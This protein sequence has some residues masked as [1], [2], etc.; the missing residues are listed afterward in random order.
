MGKNNKIP[1]PAPVDNL[2][3]TAIVKITS[4]NLLEIIKKRRSIRRF[5][6]QQVEKEKIAALLEAAMYAPSAVNK[7]PW[8]FIVIDDHAVMKRIME[9][10]PHSKMFETANIGVLVCGD[11]QLHH[12]PG[13][14][15][16]DCAAATENIL[17]AATTLGLG[18]CWVGIY[19]REDRM[20]A[21][22]EIF[23]L[24]DHVEAFAL[25]AIGYAAE[26]KNTPERFF[27]EK[28]HFNQWKV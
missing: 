23:V 26:Q 4:M 6:T 12:G 1:I 25:V 18:S 17:L 21:M 14:W 20:K 11:L 9:A 13:Y 10:H 5:T 7:Q 16:A 28:I 15:I 8:H 19:P 22:K 3:I 2:L 24:P 27:Q